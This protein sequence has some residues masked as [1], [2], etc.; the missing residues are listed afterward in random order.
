MPEMWPLNKQALGREG[1]AAKATGSPPTRKCLGGQLRLIAILPL[2]LVQILPGCRLAAF[3]DG[4][5][6]TGFLFAGDR[7]LCPL[8]HIR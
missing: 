4:P 6:L 2:F 1:E 8:V 7:S 3:G 5:W